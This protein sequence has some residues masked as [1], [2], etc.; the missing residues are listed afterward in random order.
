MSR[1]YQAGQTDDTWTRVITQ[2]DAL[3]RQGHPGEHRSLTTRG[4]V[5]Q[6]KQG[7]GDMQKAYQFLP[8][9]TSFSS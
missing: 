2:R 5:Y 8:S 3:G 6:R 1:R 9:K 7:Q 4:T